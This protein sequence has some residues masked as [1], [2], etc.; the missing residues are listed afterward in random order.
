MNELPPRAAAVYEALVWAPAIQGGADDAHLVEI[1]ESRVQRIEELLSERAQRR[2]GLSWEARVVAVR[3]GSA[4]VTVALLGPPV[5]AGAKLLERFRDFVTDVEA[6]LAEVLE[7][8]LGVPV[9]VRARLDY[10]DEE[11]VAPAAPPNGSPWERLG[12]V[13][14]AV[15]G[16]VGVVGFVTFV[17]GAV[18]WARFDG[19]GLPAEEAIS[20]VPTQNLV[21]TG[22]RTLVPAI[23]LA[24]LAVALLFLFRTFTGP[25]DERLSAR[26]QEIAQAHG[27]AIRGI[28]MGF[29]VLAGAL[30]WFAATVDDPGAWE[31]V[32]FGV[33]GVL[34]VLVTGAIATGTNR[35]P[36]LAATT[37]LAFSLF[38]GAV[39]FARERDASDVR[40][41]ALVRQNK[42]A[43]IGFFVAETG[44]RVYLGR[45][46]LKLVDGRPTNEFV[47]REQRLIA[48]DKA[49]VTDIAVGPPRDPVDA[50]HQ[51]QR[52]A[53]E[54]CDVQLPAGADAAPASARAKP[55]APTRP[56][57][58][59]W[60]RAAGE[61][62]PP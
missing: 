33:V 11:L 13:L 59:C 9:H 19:V 16:G 34:A 28:A 46:E 41:A 35:F 7:Q 56:G 52:L 37:F 21:V 30:F 14:G 3:R 25:R 2:L 49:Q 22:A 55:T 10:A 12:P 48:V 50:L 4:R 57:P 44:S 1:L 45:L 38:L 6:G 36:Y 43:T 61:R 60:S 54:L 31:W 27:D 8:A 47:E 20:V 39:S 26:G 17:G 42:K 53:D 51:A 58:N 5:R 40:A 32:A 29:G 24:L 62:P 15:A 23:V 18:H